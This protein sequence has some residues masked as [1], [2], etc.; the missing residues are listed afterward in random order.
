MNKF[1]RYLAL[2]PF[3][4]RRSEFYRDVATSIEER[5]LPRDFIEGE[6]QIATTPAT[7]DKTKAKA[8]GYMK[9]LMESGVTSLQDLLRQTMPPSDSMGIAVIEDARDK[10][11]ALRYVA[12]NVDQQTAMNKVVTSALMSPLILLPIA[13]VFSFVMAGYVIPAFEKTAPPEVWTGFAAMVRNFAE[14]FR[15]WAPWVIAGAAGIL[16][17]MFFWALE[18]LTANWRYKAESATGWYKAAWLLLGP[19]QP[20]FSLYRDIQSAR[21]LSNLSTLLR[22]NRSLQDALNELANNATPWMRRH[23]LMVIETLQ[24]N[25]GEYVLAFS[26]GIVSS[27]VLAR[28]NTKVRRDAGSDFAKILVDIGTSGQE[29]AREAVGAYAMKLNLFTLAG[30]FGIILFF[31]GGEGW[32][33]T[34]IQQEMSPGAIQRRAMEKKKAPKPPVAAPTGNSASGNGPT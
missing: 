5:E 14:L 3:W 2:F 30:V 8:L 20:I 17:W 16:G 4:K 23:L 34:R 24:M 12:E 18:N 13:M 26:G 21:M 29:K 19:I 33:V 31:Y 7:A 1:E 15:V 25:P 22:A 10:A 27:S 6:Y 28:L 32:I 11:A 9:V